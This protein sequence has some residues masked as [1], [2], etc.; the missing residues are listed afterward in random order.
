MNYQKDRQ[1]S[2]QIGQGK[3][4]GILIE[5]LHLEFRISKGSDN[6]KKT[7]KAT[8]SIYNLSAQY[9][10]YVEAEFVEVILSVGYVGLGMHKLF[11]GQ[12]TVAGTR[13]QGADI[14]TELQ[15][16]SFYT[17]LNHKRITKT[18][19]PGTT[20][21]SVIEVVKEQMY[22]VSRGVYA[23]KNVERKMVDGYPLTGSPRQILNELSEAFELEWQLDDGVLYV[24][25]RGFSYME[26]K[27]K[28]YVI[29]ETSGL[30]ERPYFDNIE[31]QRGKKD[32]LKKARKGVKLKILLNPAIVAGSVVKIEYA[33]FTGFYKVEKL[34]HNGGMYSDQWE[35]ELICGTMLTTAT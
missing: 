20:I 12:V 10:A 11:S 22:G 7:N 28:A 2:L 1:Y 26:D 25:D 17:E 34:T 5:N 6:K 23:G 4:T 32:K 31:K 16:E 18:T 21:K 33:E 8:V 35:T 14:V 29:S 15:I 3:G 13:R 9:Q 27:S 19:A 30:I 24:Q